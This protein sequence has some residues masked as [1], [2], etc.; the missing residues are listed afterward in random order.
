[1]LPKSRNERAGIITALGAI[2]KTASNKKKAPIPVGRASMYRSIKDYDTAVKENTVESF[3]QMWNDFGCKDLIP[4]D[5]L[6]R[7]VGLYREMLGPAVKF[8]RQHMRQ[9]LHE[10][11]DHQADLRDQASLNGDITVHDRTIDYYFA[12]V[13][14][15]KC[16]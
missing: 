2:Y 13:L 6:K 12:K 16:I 3:N 14:E 4:A 11:S 1:M 10:F 9:L 15:L 7:E 8:D 5:V